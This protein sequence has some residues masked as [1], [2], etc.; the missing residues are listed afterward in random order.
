MLTIF[1]TVLWTVTFLGQPLLILLRCL[2]LG[3]FIIRNDEEK[4]RKIFKILEKITISSSMAFHHGKLSPS[5]SFLGRNCIGYYMIGDRND[6]L[7]GQIH[8]ITTRDVFNELIKSEE[9]TVHP[10][11]L[12]L[13]QP[14]QKTITFFNRTGTYSNI[15]YSQRKLDVTSIVPQGEQA[16]IISDIISIFKTRGRATIF[17][18]GVSGAGK[19]TIGVLLAKELSGSFCH[20]FNPTSPG[21]TLHSLARDAEIAEEDGKALVIVIEEVNTLIHSVHTNAIELHKDV[22]TLVYNKSTYNTFLDDMILYQN[23]LLI[24]TSNET[25]E[26]LDD[27]DP[28]YLRKGRVDA[29]YSMMKQLEI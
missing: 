27:L 20:T 3:Y 16:N 10:K 8:I 5:G 1:S 9:V 15:Y 22:Q 18:Q 23:I 17:L 12:E 26:E 4:V 11:T 7:S 2:G 25:K 28:C 21:D 29:H 13:I 24:L 14:K 6:G 19:S